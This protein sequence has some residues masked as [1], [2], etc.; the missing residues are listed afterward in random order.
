LR[1]LDVKRVLLISTHGIVTLNRFH[2]LNADLSGDFERFGHPGLAFEHPADTD[3]VRS[4]VSAAEAQNVPLTATRLWEQSDHSV[5]VPITLLKD[6]LPSSIAIVSISFRPPDDHYRL[7]QAIGEALSEMPEP[8]AILASGDAV[9][10]LNEDSP[11]GRH[12]SGE[13]VQQQYEAA[14]SDWDDRSLLEID[15]SLRRDVDESVI[16][17]TLILMGALQGLNANPRILCSEHPWGVG[18]VTALVEIARES[19]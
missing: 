17:P 19:S 16:S 13:Q 5:G 6:Q 2:V 4:I 14:L 12:P 1:E 15:E 8:T 9:H 11:K 18:Y 7:G 3:L 10:R